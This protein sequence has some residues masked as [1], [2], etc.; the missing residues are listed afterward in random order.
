MASR[1]WPR[2]YSMGMAALR[3]RPRRTPPR[4]VRRVLVVQHFL[5][6]DTVM[7]TPLLK[8]ARSR[9]P[10]ADI[11][12]AL[13]E[14]FAPLYA[15]KP[16]GVQALPFDARSLS[17]H[18]ELVRHGGFDLA[19]VPGDNR[20]SW[21]AR[22]MRSR[23]IVGFA[24]D[25]RTYRDWPIDEARALPAEPMSWG[26]MAATLLD[27]PEPEPYSLGEWPAPPFRPYARPAGRYCVLHPG[28]RNPNRLWPAERWRLVIDAVEAKGY[29]TV[30]TCGPG[31]EALA[32]SLDP[33]GTRSL[34]AGRLDLPQLWDLL[35]GA[36]L[37]ACP[38]TGIAHLARLVGVPTVAIYGQ[39]SP[40]S[41]GAGR[42]WAAS[43]FKALWDEDV[44][45][46]DD[47]TLFG[48][49]LQ[50]LRQCARTPDECAD[51]FCIRRIAPDQV[52]SSIEDLLPRP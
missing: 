39:G 7:L 10:A 37:L 26:D 52:T 23:W 1:A 47:Q 11:V 2:A 22:A 20:W 12:M 13:P 31:E 8:K 19:L 48:R 21:L 14:A 25:E 18:R 43:P 35:A 45:C 34:L 29:A 5:L 46:R 6:G 38:D 40:I 16:Y 42:F 49:R 30:I 28:A 9:F 51:P 44:A 33:T 17:A 41:T 50:W 36:S 4:E 24:A 3:W 15:G 27:G 32:R